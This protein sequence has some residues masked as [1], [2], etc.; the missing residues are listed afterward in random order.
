M[1]ALAGAV[2]LGLAA[3]AFARLGEI[4]QSLFIRL[5]TAFPMVPFVF[6][7]AMFAGVVWMTRRWWPAARGSGIPQVMAASHD[8]E[9]QKQGNLVS[10]RT[11]L[12]KFGCT[13]AMLLSGGSVG[14][15]GPTVQISAALMVAVH[16]WLR[17]P[18]SAGII[19]AAARR[20][21]RRRSTRRWRAWP[22]PLRSWPPPS[23][24]RSPCW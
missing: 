18:V 24:R 8:P 1:A 4:A 21:W 20:A 22:S 5:S 13:L 15:E 6:T 14:R 16:R 12:A 11:A 2:L 9:A 10:L 3:I 19:I 17:V 23:S 7:P